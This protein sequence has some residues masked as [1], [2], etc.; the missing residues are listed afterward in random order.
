MEMVFNIRDTN[1]RKC[2]WKK[3]EFWLYL[4]SG[5]TIA[6]ESSC[7]A[8]YD[9]LFKKWIYTIKEWRTG[10]WDRFV[11]AEPLSDIDTDTEIEDFYE[12]EWFFK[13]QEAYNKARSWAIVTFTWTYTYLSWGEP[14]TWNISDLLLWDGVEFYRIVRVYGIYNKDAT[15][16]TSNDAIS[17]WDPKLT[18]STPKEMRFCVKT[19]YKMGIWNHSSELCSIMTNFME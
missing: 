18:D 3:D 9:K 6:N 11:Y 14:V 2:S 13:N 1:W 10:S 15:S 12:I 7:K 8:G 5:E 16:P 4:G 19:F 17:S